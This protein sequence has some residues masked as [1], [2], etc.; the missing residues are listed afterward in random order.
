MRVLPERF[1]L[2]CGGS[3]VQVAYVVYLVAGPVLDANQFTR[4]KLLVT[5]VQ[6]SA[7]SW[8]TFSHAVLAG[9]TRRS[10]DVWSLP[11]RGE[12]GGE[13]RGRS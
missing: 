10:W 5:M 6:V 13:S 11:F 12:R 9:G 8:R 4:L 1:L 7:G 2:P 3:V